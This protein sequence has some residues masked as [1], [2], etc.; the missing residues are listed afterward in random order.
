[1]KIKTYLLILL[2]T[3]FLTA[4]S[5]DLSLSTDADNVTSAAAKIADFDLPAGY[6][7]DFTTTVM[8]YEV[9]AYTR[10]DGPSH[11]YL[12]QSEDAADWEKLAQALDEIVIGSGDPHTRLTVVD[13]R[14]VMVR[15]QESTLVISD[16]VNSEGRAYRQAAVG[17]QGNGGPALLVFSESA[18]KWDQAALDALL[19]S[20]E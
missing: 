20:I 16:A 10:G 1:M 13:T 7:A 2:I 11:I 14:S 15:G 17:F 12:I 19:A 18:E 3:L 9:A 8:G 4:C 5:V 6:S